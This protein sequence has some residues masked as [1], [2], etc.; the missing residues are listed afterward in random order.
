MTLIRTLNGDIQAANVTGVLPGRDDRA[1]W[2]LDGTSV[3][4]DQA[5]KMAAAREAMVVSRMQAL[6]AMRRAGI[7]AEVEAIVAAAGVTDPEVIDAWENAIEF[8][9][10]STLLANLNALRTTPLTDAELDALFVAA[11]QIGA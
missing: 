2:S 1:F 6:I 11:A 10:D 3:V 7:L 5:A 4:V 8:R 9:R